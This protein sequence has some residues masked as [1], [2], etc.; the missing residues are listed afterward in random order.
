MYLGVQCLPQLTRSAGEI[1]YQLVRV[2]HVDR[3]PMGLQPL[4]NGVAILVGHTESFAELLR[5]ESMMKV[6]RRLVV[7]VMNKLVQFLLLRR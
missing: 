7:K 5:R 3:N 4:L 1:N 2:L 6:G